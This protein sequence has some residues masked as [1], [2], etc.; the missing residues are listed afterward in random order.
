ARASLICLP[1]NKHLLLFTLPALCADTARL[2]NLAGEFIDQYNAAY[3]GEEFVEEPLQYAEL[4]EWQHELLT[5]ADTQA[6]RDFWSQQFHSTDCATSLPG[7]NGLSSA[8]QPER[9]SLVLSERE[10]ERSREVA[11]EL[12]CSLAELWLSCWQVLLS[13][14]S[15]AAE[16]TVGVCGN[17]RNE[18]EVERALGLLSRYVPVSSRC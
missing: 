7:V 12:D 13:R 1:T 16:V 11:A 4:A 6:G 17:G 15:G 10:L 14:L 3:R 9:V 18:T 2:I 8:W 5:S